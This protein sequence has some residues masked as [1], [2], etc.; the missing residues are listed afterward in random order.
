MDIERQKL[1][2]RS[3]SHA[4]LQLLFLHSHF[5][6]GLF[7][8]SLENLIDNLYMCIMVWGLDNIFCIF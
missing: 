6:L 4:E 7:L 2:K 5:G 3:L 8:D 1:N